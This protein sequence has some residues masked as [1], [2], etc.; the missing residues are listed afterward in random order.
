MPLIKYAQYL[1]YPDGNPVDTMPYPVQLLGG[2]ILVPT[3]AD[4]AGTTPLAN[5]VLTDTDGLL[6]FY[7]AP[8]SFFTDVSGTLF[9]YL[10]DDTEPDDAWPG[11]FVHAQASP[12]SVWTIEHH[13]GVEPE[14]TVLVAAQASEGDVTHPDDETTIIT[15][16][17]PVSGTA[18]LRR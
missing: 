4:K 6:T 8:G 15:F 2:N 3:F 16:G 14:V 17:S 18:L 7:A 10:V 1:T 5:P 12:A 9:H 11:T 13:F